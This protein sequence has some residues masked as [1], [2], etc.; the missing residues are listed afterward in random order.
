MV[1]LTIW[2]KHMSD[3]GDISTEQRG[4]MWLMG[5]NRPAKY[6]GL[7]PHMFK[8]LAAAYD[9]LEHDPALRVGILFGHGAHLTAGLDLPQFTAAM[10][11]GN[12]PMQVANA[13][14]PFKLK[15]PARTKPVITAARGISYTAGLEMALGGD[16]V[17]AASDAR[18]RM[19]ET[20]RS[21]MPTGGATFR[22]IER[23]GW[24]NAM[25]WLLT[26]DEFSA[27]EA[28]RIG[29]V[30]EIVEPGAELATAIAI[31]ERIASA[32]PLAVQATLA[33]AM[34]YAKQGE[35]AAIAA[36]APT[37][38]RLSATEDFAEGVQSFIERREAVF[39][40]R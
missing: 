40:G 16:I 30:Q 11:G 7:T 38:K 39:K 12:D 2:E 17:I 6:N 19:I 32:A 15:G 27:A 35:D 29:L 8:K 20:R 25:R 21:L 36:F 4:H 26:G 3:D 33:N 5:L 34:L 9:M 37:Q 18:F 10:A 14:D 22:F 24:G 28:Y 1:C 31:A 13:V 23:G